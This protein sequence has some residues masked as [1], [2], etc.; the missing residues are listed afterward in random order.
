MPNCKPV[1]VGR[2]SDVRYM[3]PSPRPTTPSLSVKTFRVNS[4]LQLS[5]QHIILLRETQEWKDKDTVLMLNIRTP[6]FLTI[7][8]LKFKC[9][10]YHILICLKTTGHLAKVLLL[11]LYIVTFRHFSYI[12]L[13][14]CVHYSQFILFI[15]NLSS[16]EQGEL[17]SSHLQ[18]SE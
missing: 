5:N 1:S 4:I 18:Y 6:L 17:P 9:P 7:L 14:E 13:C 3:T 8:V 12:C 10:F 2:S 16:P 11:Q 15:I